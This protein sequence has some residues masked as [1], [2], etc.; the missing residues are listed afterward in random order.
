MAVRM[1][2]WLKMLWNAKYSEKSAFCFQKLHAVVFLELRPWQMMQWN[3]LFAG[4]RQCHVISQ[5][6]GVDWTSL[7]KQVFDGLQQITNTGQSSRKK[8]NGGLFL[9]QW[10][11]FI[12]ALDRSG[13]EKVWDYIL[14]SYRRMPMHKRSLNIVCQILILTLANFWF[15]IVWMNIT[16]L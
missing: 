2:F 10:A 15:V 11:L 3:F 9:T 4:E 1:L 8:R 7:I 13:F 6:W 16:C 12:L 5:G 14:K